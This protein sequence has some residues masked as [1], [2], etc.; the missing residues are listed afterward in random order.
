MRRNRPLG[1]STI[2]GVESLLEGLPSL[3]SDSR[4]HAN[5][6]H[7]AALSVIDEGIHIVDVSGK[8]IF[9]NAAMGS[10]EG[11]DPS[12]VLGKPLHAVFPGLSLESSTL[13]RVLKTG[14]P[15]HDLVQ[16]YETPTGDTV[17]TVNSTIP[18]L[19]EGNCVAAIEVAK[20]LT[21]VRRLSQQVEELPD[22]KQKKP[23]ARRRARLRSNDTLYTFD[24]I[25][26]SS[27]AIV[28]AKLLAKSAAKRDSPILIWGPTGTGKEMFAQSI[29]NDSR[30]SSGRFVAVNCSAL[31]ESLA[32]S[33]LFG[34]VRG[35]FTGSLDNEGL[36]EQ[37]DGGTLFLDEI[38]SAGLA[39]QSKLLR[40]VEER[41]VRRV[42]GNRLIPV[43]VHVLAASN[44]DPTQAIRDGH[45]RS[46]LYYRLAATSIGIPPLSERRQ[47]IDPLVQEMT[48]K[49][50]RYLEIAAPKYTERAMQCLRNYPWPGNARELRNV[51]ESILTLSPGKRLIDIE[52]LP[53]AIAG[54]GSPERLEP[55]QTT[56]NDVL[57]HNEARL[58]ERALLEEG[59]NMSR[60]AKRLGISR[61]SLYY[62]MAKYGIAKP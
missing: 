19:V 61:Q 11:I 53:S 46:D 44:V 8:T 29:H 50:A 26:G 36:F 31:P 39:L 7:F 21:R 6:V 2:F 49:H 16:T 15:I 13:L 34:N 57:A 23:A 62:R 45:L 60:T 18:I 55:A 43:D 52:D 35:A 3:T 28:Q 30:R 17:T 42:G 25:L 1:G 14:K 22:A 37:A 41:A 27:P 40:V 5:L 56:I 38:N 12:K 33:T 32:E 59:S 58:I 24:D 10:I 48:R 20:T 51:I 54:D 9:Y 47:D 4:S